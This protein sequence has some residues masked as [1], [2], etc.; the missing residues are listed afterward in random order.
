MGN[1]DNDKEPLLD[2]YQED[3]DGEEWI[4]IKINLWFLVGL[5]L[6][7]IYIPSQYLYL[8]GNK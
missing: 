5:L 4:I 6:L 7:I 3:R 2:I 1:F 8:F